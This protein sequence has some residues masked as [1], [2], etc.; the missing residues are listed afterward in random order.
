MN[1]YLQSWSSLFRRT[2]RWLDAVW[3]SRPVLRLA[4]VGILA[5]LAARLDRPFVANV[6]PDDLAPGADAVVE[7]ATQPKLAAA[8]TSPAPLYFA[9]CGYTQS[10]RVRPLLA[11]SAVL[12]SDRKSTRLNSS[13]RT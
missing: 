8:F 10:G 6:L 1:V 4:A 9:H 3:D 5:G 2:P 12:P 13:H 7:G 11:A